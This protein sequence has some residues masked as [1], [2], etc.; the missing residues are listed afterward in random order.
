VAA[1]VLRG[2]AILGGVALIERFQFV[3][4]ALGATLLVLAW[5]IFKAAGEE[6]DPGRNAAVRVLRRL[7]PRATP[8]MTCLAAIVLADTSTRRSPWC[9]GSWA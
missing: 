8:I 2:M 7:M 4:Y 6:P 5:R 9:W 1:L 3:V